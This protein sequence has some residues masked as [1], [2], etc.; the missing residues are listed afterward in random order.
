MSYVEGSTN[1]QFNISSKLNNFKH[2]IPSASYVAGFIDCDGCVF[3]RKIKN[4]FQTGIQISQ[5]KINILLILKYHFGGIIKKQLNKWILIIKSDDYELLINYIYHHTIIKMIQIK[6]LKQMLKYVGKNKMDDEKTKQFE[7][8]S[9]ANK[10]NLFDEHNLLKINIDYISGIFDSDG[11]MYISK[12]RINKFYISISQKSYLSV[13]TCIQNY[14]GFGNVNYKEGKYK[15]YSKENCLK[16]IELIENNLI[17]KYNQ[18]QHFKHYLLSNNYDIKYKMYEKC[19]YETHD[20]NEFNFENCGDIVNDNAS[21][22]L[23]KINYKNKMQCLNDIYRNTIQTGINMRVNVCDEVSSGLQSDLSGTDFKKNVTSVC[24]DFDCKLNNELDNELNNE[25]IYDQIN[26]INDNLLHF[27]RFRNRIPSPSYVAG[28]IDGDGYIFIRKYKDDSG[29]QSGIVMTQSR[30]NILLIFKYYFG[31]NIYKSHLSRTLG[32]KNRKFQYEL[33]I[34]SNYYEFLLNYIYHHI[35]IKT[36]QIQALKKMFKYVGVTNKTNERKEQFTQCFSAN[37]YKFFDEFHLTKI[38]VDYI[39]GLFDAEGCFYINVNE[40]NHFAISISQK[41]YMKILEYIKNY[42]GIGQINYS[43]YSYS[44]TLKK[45]CLLFIHLIENNLIVKY[46]QSQYFKQ[47]LLSKDVT[48]KY[49]LYKKC[50]Y[51][52]RVTDEYTNDSYNDIHASNNHKKMNAIYKNKQNVLHNIK[53][54]IEKIE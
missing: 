31:G 12:S 1:M 15:I 28:C 20:N 39:S 2:V 44:I 5:T 14:L 35:V 50:K 29:F 49:N 25:V 46:N 40:I 51:E 36:Q 38:N 16:F 33:K 34:R 43:S 41:S 32:N 26:V 18:T 47:Y 17:V 22:T 8:C 7:F 11:C 6:C 19:N 53:C 24:N 52:K 13:L 21:F 23:N 37:K 48:T 4:G 10:N 45:E 54:T 3:I 9:N 30:I 27:N 42:L